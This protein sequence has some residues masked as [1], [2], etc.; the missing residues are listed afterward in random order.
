MENK[1]R[2]RVFWFNFNNN[3]EDNKDFIRTRDFEYMMFYEA[4]DTK[5]ISGYI[6]FKNQRL[7]KSVETKTFLNRATVKPETRSEKKSKRIIRKC[8][9][10]MNMELPQIKEPELILL[11]YQKHLINLFKKV[12]K[13][14]K[15]LINSSNQSKTITHL[16]QNK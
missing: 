16:T 4:K 12:Q 2:C 9:K 10:F 8:I 5:I 1:Q 6:R 15:K 14:T 7:Q 13:K 11:K 3:S